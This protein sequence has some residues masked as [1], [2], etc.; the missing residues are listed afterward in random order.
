MQ[1]TVEGG[2][3]GFFKAH[4]STGGVKGRLSYYLSAADTE[5]DGYREHSEQGRQR[6]FSNL[7]WRFT[8]STTARLDLVYVNAAERYPNALTAAGIRHQDI[9]TIPEYVNNNW[10]RYQN[11]TR[12]ALDVRHVIN[13]NHE[14]EFIAFSQYRDLWHPIFQILDQDTRA[15]GGEIRYRA[16]GTLFGKRDRFV[17]GFTPQLGTQEQRN[18]TNVG[19][20]AGTSRLPPS[21]PSTNAGFYFDNQLD[22]RD[23]VTLSIGGRF[24]HSNRRYTD[25]LSCRWGPFGRAAIQGVLSQDRRF[26]AGQATRSRSLE[27]SA[28]HTSLR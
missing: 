11:G 9:E 21:R 5:Y 1:A 7:G 28:A 17:G 25:L 10:G 2:S 22:L 12:A 23:N 8:P 15:F 16:S 6:V 3:F 13:D 14:I 20:N 18:W 24:D 27:T 19:G 4:A 26:L